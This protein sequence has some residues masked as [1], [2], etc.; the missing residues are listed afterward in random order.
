MRSNEPV[1]SIVFVGKEK[2]A[3]SGNR[4]V[5]LADRRGNAMTV[6]RKSEVWARKVFLAVEHNPA[7]IYIT[8][9][10]GN[11]EYVNNTFVE[12]SGYSRDEV[13]G[14]NARMLRPEQR[15][16]SVYF[17]LWTTLK[18]GRTW[19]G[20]LQTRR[21]DG[22]LHWERMLLTPIRDDEGRVPTS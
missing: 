19:K 5:R 9:I 22:T 18:A 16:E 12:T 1:A 3:G 8:D 7:T 13:I 4:R 21:R 6:R 2:D 15:D 14:R 17:E 20:E 10:D 11:I